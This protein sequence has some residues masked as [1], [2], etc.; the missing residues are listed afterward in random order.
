MFDIEGAR[1]AGYSEED[2]SEELSLGGQFDV[3]AA[4]RSGYTLE[5]IATEVSQA[6]EGP[7]VG[8]TPQDLSMEALEAAG[9]TEGID[10]NLSFAREMASNIPGSALE[11]GK[12]MASLV[13]PE[14]WKGL[15]KT[16]LG[17][18]ELLIPG[19]QGQE[20]LAEGVG[21]MYAERYGGIEKLQ[22]TVK[23]DPVG[24]AMDVAGMLTLV[25]G[26]LGWVGRAGKIAP[27]AK[28]GAAM[29]ETGAA[30][31]PLAIASKGVGAVYKT[32][33]R[34]GKE[35]AGFTSGV[36]GAATEEALRGS[37]AFKGALR[38]TTTGKE[39]VEETRMALRQF[40]SKKVTQYRAEM[41]KIKGI[42]GDL[43]ITPVKEALKD[44]MD[45]LGIEIIE[46]QEFKRG[47]R[48]KV[49]EEFDY[50]R[51]PAISSAQEADMTKM[52]K[53]INEWGDRPGDLTA[54]GVDKLKRSIDDFYAP[55]EKSRVMVADLRKKCK[56]L[57]VE[58]VP[59]YEKL[60]KEYSI[61]ADMQ[62]DIVK[63]LS[64]EGTKGADTVLRKLITGIKESDDF[65]RTLMDELRGASGKDI[66][67]MISG[68]M[69]STYVPSGYIARLGTAAIGYGAIFNPKM[70]G[71]I[72]IASPRLVA[73][74]LGAIGKGERLV[75]RMGRSTLAQPGAR[76]AAFQ[77]GRVGLMPEMTE[78]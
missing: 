12:G 14:T 19:E 38:G 8:R 42:E 45:N 66:R 57:L 51:A 50:S 25:G 15:G 40:S 7:A 35:A 61:L 65:R 48:V 16:A 26:V 36:G 24:F 62:D 49:T 41:K 52:I 31:D 68:K 21:K 78:Y 58:K 20:K 59:G 69:M 74:M 55:T 37:E 30:I 39:I 34:G 60:T 13:K 63:A 53:L 10:R 5:E 70:L 2:I 23:K 4:L 9:A 72:A 32:V 27:L 73:T 17:G 71:L 1:R 67:A 6:Q 64:L 33:R 3:K 47:G 43:D 29:A 54:F 76:Q 46:K 44:Q 18:I 77:A 22:E 75:G 28:T 56:D 11:V